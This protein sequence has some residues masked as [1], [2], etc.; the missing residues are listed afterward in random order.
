[1]NIRKIL[2]YW[3]AGLLAVLMIGALLFP[4]EN[5]LASDDRSAHVQQSGRPN[6]DAL[7]STPKRSAELKEAPKFENGRMVQTEPRFDVPTFLW[8]ADEG[9]AKT[10]SADAVQRS[11][12]IEASA[13][14]H[15][16]GY[17]SRYRLVKSDVAE[18][19]VA[20]IHDTGNGAIIVK[21]KQTFGGV[22][23][24]RDE[25]NVIMNRGLQLVALSGYLTFF[26]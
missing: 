1:M 16:S 19:S 14:G 10:L 2:P 21:F 7:A 12:D 6:F 25:I 13:R 3:L 18:A 22:E 26:C 17:A 23:V 8:A 4:M 15:L 11:N 20:S 9:N 5:G 24:F